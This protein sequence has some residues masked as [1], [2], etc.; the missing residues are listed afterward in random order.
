MPSIN[1]RKRS[2]LNNGLLIL[3]SFFFLVPPII[4]GLNPERVNVVVHNFVSLSCEAT[5]FPPPTLTWLN[6]RG[7]VQARTNALIMPGMVST[8]HMMWISF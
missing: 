1:Q 7:P 6:E 5:G 8:G 4:I 3:I 2:K